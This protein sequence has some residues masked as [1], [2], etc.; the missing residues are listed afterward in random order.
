MILRFW[1]CPCLAKPIIFNLRGPN[2]P[3]IIQGKS[4]VI[5]EFVIGNFEML[6]PFQKWKR[7]GPNHAADPSNT[8]FEI[9]TTGSISSKKHEMEILENLEYEIYKKH[10]MEIWQY[11]SNIFKKTWNGQFVFSIIETW[12][13]DFYEPQ[14]LTIVLMK[15]VHH[16]S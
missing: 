1:R 10:E 16:P 12:T 13:I 7:R 14:Q 8:C 3:K 6:D 11:G 9:L 4:W 2:L 5:F 15:G